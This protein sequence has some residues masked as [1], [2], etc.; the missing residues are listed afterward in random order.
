MWEMFPEEIHSRCSGTMEPWEWFAAA[1][2]AKMNR[3]GGV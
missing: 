1:C 2:R 3:H